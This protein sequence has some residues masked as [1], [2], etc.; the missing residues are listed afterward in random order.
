VIDIGIAIAGGGIAG[1]SAAYHLTKHDHHDYMVFEREGEVGGAARSIQTADNFTFDYASHILYTKSTYVAQL[2]EKL[3][4]DN[5]LEAQRDAWIF[6]KGVFTR[7]PFQANLYGLPID[8]VEECLIGFVDA[9]RQSHSRD[10]CNFESWIHAT[11]GSGI[12]E[13]FMLP[14]NRK[15]WKYSLQLMSHDWVGNRVPRPSLEDVIR[16]ALTD[17]HKGVG[18]NKTFVY[19]RAG[20]IGAIPAR[21]YELLG[22]DRPKVITGAAIV[23]I[24]PIDRRLE[25]ADGQSIHYRY[26]ILTLP[27]PSLLGLLLGSFPC[28]VQQALE[29]LE[30]NRLYCLCFGVKGRILGDWMRIYL[31]EE[32]FLTHRLG[33]PTAVSPAMA[34]P[35]W[36]SLYAEITEPRVPLHTITEL[37]MVDRTISDLRRI[38]IIERREEI[39]YKGRLTLDPAYVIYTLSRDKDVQVIHQFLRQHDIYPA[40]RFGD[41]HYYN[42]DHTILSGKSIVEELLK[43][44]CGRIDDR[45]GRMVFLDNEH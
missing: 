17:D 20:G 39:E 29:R 14:Y 26:L 38:G 19:P 40:G 10:M 45:K 33:F 7:Y 34:P 16:G 15:L 43:I 37:E 42:V 35:G 32:D 6:S 27:L 2:Y 13:H 8:V 4:G 18:P 21:F 25:L 1:L 41:W 44:M 9:L 30:Y 28:Q 22:P 23:G 31:P 11:Y 3:L 5:V 24:D 36:G 12:A